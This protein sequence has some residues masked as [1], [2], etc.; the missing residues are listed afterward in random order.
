MESFP[1]YASVPCWEVMGWNDYAAT[2]NHILASRRMPNHRLSRFM[3]NLEL[4]LSERHPLYPA[5]DHST[6]FYTHHTNMWY[7]AGIEMAMECQE[8]SNPLTPLERGERYLR[9]NGYITTNHGPHPCDYCGRG[10]AIGVVC[11]RL[12]LCES[13]LCSEA[14]AIKKL[15]AT[16][17][18]DLWLQKF[19][20]STA[21]LGPDGSPYNRLDCP[22]PEDSDEWQ[23][24][25]AAVP[26]L[27]IDCE[28]DPLYQAAQRV[29]RKPMAAVQKV[30]VPIT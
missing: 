7:H 27:D 22:I 4:F 25:F 20:G 2:V 12:I 28:R 14:C 8:A 30:R 10:F 29:V 21:G 5:A 16:I 15:M 13:I 19:Y 6:S 26:R 11:D 18:S 3:R 17:R 9:L 1:Q 23:A 24:W